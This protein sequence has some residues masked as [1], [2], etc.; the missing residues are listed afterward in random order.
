VTA[1]SRPFTLPESAFTVTT[2]LVVRVV[3]GSSYGT[4]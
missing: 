2:T 1:A 3:A 4:I